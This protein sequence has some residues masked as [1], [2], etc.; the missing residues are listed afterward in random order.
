MWNRSSS[1]LGDALRF[2]SSDILES[3]VD[4]LLAPDLGLTLADPGQLEQVLM[5]LVI[6]AR[7]ASYPRTCGGPSLCTVILL[8]D[9]CP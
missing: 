3:K 8:L 6:N 9:S 4:D 2:A 7:A 5:N 1:N